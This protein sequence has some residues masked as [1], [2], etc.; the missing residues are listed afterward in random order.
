MKKFTK[1][2]V[3]IIAVLLML[4]VSI[5][6]SDAVSSYQF[7]Y[8]GVTIGID[9]KAK[10]FIKKAGKVKKKS[11]KKSC[12]YKGY[13]RAYRYK[14]FTLSTYSKSKK[15]AE[16][17]NGITFTSSKVKTKEGLKIGSKES[18][19]IKKYGKKYNKLQYET[20]NRY[21]YTKGKSKLQIQIKNKKVSKITY[22]K[23]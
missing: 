16:Y 5:Y 4:C 15:G 9:S 12:A 20:N 13:D 6:P 14:Y 21:V 10:T 18:T 19:V 11:T 17:V 7:K 8:N 22:L 3:S 23:K 1:V 2:T